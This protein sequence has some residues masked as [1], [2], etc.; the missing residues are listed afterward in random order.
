[1]MPNCCVKTL[2]AL[3]PSCDI[4]TNSILLYW[5]YK[6]FGRSSFPM[7]FST[8]CCVAKMVPVLFGVYC[9]IIGCEYVYQ[10]CY[11]AAIK[12]CFRHKLRIMSCTHLVQIGLNLTDVTEHYALS[13]ECCFFDVVV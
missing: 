9:Q 4:F 8:E 5:I 2:S 3:Q 11:F 7:I 12:L 13:C 10:C 1:M 6:N